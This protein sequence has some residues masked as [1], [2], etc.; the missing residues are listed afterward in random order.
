[1]R[2]TTSMKRLTTHQEGMVSIF[3]AT[4][5]IIILG[6]LAMAFAQ[7]SRRE[8]RESLDSQLSAQ[9]F[10]AAESGI[11]DAKAEIL[12]YASTHAGTIVEKKT[13]DDSTSPYS[14]DHSLNS[15]DNVSYTCVMIDP[16]PKALTVKLSGSDQVIPIKSADGNG[17]NSITLSWD[18]ASSVTNAV[19][20]TC[21]ALGTFPSA[22]AWTCPFGGVRAELVDVDKGLSSAALLANDMAAFLMPISNGSGTLSFQASSSGVTKGKVV[23][24]K[25][26]GNGTCSVVITG[27]GDK[28]YYL[29]V[30][31]LYMNS[32][33]VI[34]GTTAGGGA[35]EFKDGQIQIDSTG[36]AQDVLRRMVVSVPYESAT[37]IPGAAI[38]SNNS[39]CKKFRVNNAY[40]DPG[41]C[42]Y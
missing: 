3:V 24:A 33:L 7:I 19:M 36:K 31:S 2:I 29:R 14:F 1:M 37:K 38:T 8:Q 22:D 12:S 21:P 25:G 13:C 26:C 39:I 5:L 20:A 30:R 4:L 40:Y 6:L 18:A 16:T 23:D 15:T 42:A 28:D 34:T 17:F 35:A 27:L 41:D 9:A 10:Y 11:N 32:N